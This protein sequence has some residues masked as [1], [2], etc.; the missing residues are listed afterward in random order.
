MTGT[1]LQS[2]QVFLTDQPGRDRK[3]GMSELDSKDWTVGTGELGT[4]VL[5]QDSCDRTGGT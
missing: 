3:D 1:V 5:E 4:T 2:G